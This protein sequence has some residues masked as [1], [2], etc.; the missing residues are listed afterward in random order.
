MQLGFEKSTIF[1][2][3]KHVVAPKGKHYPMVTPSC[4]VPAPVNFHSL[5]PTSVAS[6][7]VHSSFEI[8]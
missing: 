4:G 7:M 1:L 5:W 6:I 8:L 3:L 2:L